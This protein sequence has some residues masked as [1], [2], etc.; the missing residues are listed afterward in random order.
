L[1]GEFDATAVNGV[2]HEYDEDLWRIVAHDQTSRSLGNV[3]SQ[4]TSA[5]Q[6]RLDEFDDDR[7]ATLRAVAVPHLTVQDGVRCGGGVKARSV[8]LADAS[9]TTGQCL[10]AAA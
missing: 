10:R 1:A 2:L 7:Q 4:A 9:Q 3:Y 6:E 5:A 8:M